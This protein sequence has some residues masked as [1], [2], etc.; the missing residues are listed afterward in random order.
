MWLCP[1]SW[2]YSGL[3]LFVNLAET[4]LFI[5]TTSFSDTVKRK[6]R[7]VMVQGVF[8]MKQIFAIAAIG[9]CLTGLGASSAQALTAIEISQLKKLDP[10]TRLEQR[11]DIEAMIRLK[12]EARWAPDKVLAYAYSDPKLSRHR[13]QADGAAFRSRGKWYHLSYDC[14][15]APDHLTITAFNYKIGK[16]IPQSHWQAHYLV[17]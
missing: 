9:L 2:K 14:S 7:S 16:L 6:A 12:R 13:I 15:A 1:S 5:N 17:P 11:C 4:D 8:F 10:Q 3:L